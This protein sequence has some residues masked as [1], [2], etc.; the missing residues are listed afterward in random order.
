MFMQLLLI[1]IHWVPTWQMM[2]FLISKIFKYCISYIFFNNQ[3]CSGFSCDIYIYNIKICEIFSSYV[4][5]KE[6]LYIFYIK[7]IKYVLCT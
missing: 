7:S 3:R 5:C 4:Y 2:D 6:N 1:R